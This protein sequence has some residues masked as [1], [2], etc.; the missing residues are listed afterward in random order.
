L[1]DDL[2]DLEQL[3]L[4]DE[5][6]RLVKVAI[7]RIASAASEIPDCGFFKRSILDEVEQFSEV[8][9]RWNGHRGTHSRNIEGRKSALKKL[10]KARQRIA[11]R[12]YINQYVLEN[13]LDVKLLEATHM[14]FVD[15]VR[16]GPALF[17]GIAVTLEKLATNS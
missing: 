11:K 17:K 15:L 2:A 8:Y 1:L 6:C 9:D 16:S 13:D 4:N 3:W 10:R 12:I 7:S 5:H 14:A